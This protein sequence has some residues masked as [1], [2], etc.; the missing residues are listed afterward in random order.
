VSGLVHIAEGEGKESQIVG[1]ATL[2][3]WATDFHT[4]KFLAKVLT[5]DGDFRKKLSSVKWA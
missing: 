4:G 5:F 1:T 2:K 3:L